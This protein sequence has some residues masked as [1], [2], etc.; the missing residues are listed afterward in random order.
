MQ[1]GRI[2][3][4]GYQSFMQDCDTAPVLNTVG[5]DLYNLFESCCLGS[6]SDEVGGIV[7]NDLYSSSLVLTCKNKVNKE[8]IISGLDNLDE[9]TQIT[10]Y[11]S[12]SKNRYLEYE[13]SEGAVLVVCTKAATSANSVLKM[14]EEADFIDFD[15]KYFRKDICKLSI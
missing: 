8:N 12:V 10:F 1:D 14:Y 6:F 7:Y 4:L 13:A 9:D 3:I 2:S 11:P 5:D 15:S